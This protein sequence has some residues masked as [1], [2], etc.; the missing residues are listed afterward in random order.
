MDLKGKIPAP[1]DRE[2]GKPKKKEKIK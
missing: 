2:A 1:C